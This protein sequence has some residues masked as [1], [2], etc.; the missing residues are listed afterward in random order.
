MQ[1]TGIQI[2]GLLLR[3]ATV[4]RT[5][6]N[7]QI[8]SLLCDSI[9]DPC[10]PDLQTSPP[11]TLSFRKT[12]NRR[13]ERSSEPVN[14]S[15][16]SRTLVSGLHSNDLIV[17]SRTFA[18]ARSR[19][20]RQALILQVEAQLHLKAEELIT[21]SQFETQEKR[22]TTYSTTHSALNEHLEAF[23][24]LNL[25]PERVSAVPAALKAFV[26]WKKPEIPSYF[27]LDIGLN[28]T[29]CIWVENGLLQKSHAISSGLQQLKNSFLE[30]RKKTPH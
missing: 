24:R 3:R 28:A 14:T 6:Q 9:N 12:K 26:Q 25:N 17:R 22:A 4:K 16:S 27:V 5:R 23:H 29:N 2:D 21:V 18:P 10:K 30:E 11:K 8:C 7:L 19:K 15:L 13:A 1:A 20:L